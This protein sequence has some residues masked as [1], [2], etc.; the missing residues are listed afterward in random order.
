MLNLLLSI[1]LFAVL[2]FELLAAFVPQGGAAG[3]ILWLLLSLSLAV[4]A[5]YEIGFLLARFLRGRAVLTPLVLGVLFFLILSNIS[6]PY[7]LSHEFTQ[8]LGCALT[9]YNEQPGWGFRETCLFGYPA[10]QFFLPGVPSVLFGRSQETLNFGGSIWLLIGLSLFAAGLYRHFGRESSLRGDVLSAFALSLI[11]HFYYFNHFTFLYEQSIFPP[12]F[13]L[14]VVGLFA[15][16]FASNLYTYFLLGCTALLLAIYSYTPSMALVALG[17]AG[18]A[19]GFLTKNLPRKSAAL[20]LVLIGA[21]AAVSYTFRYDGTVSD[22]GTPASK[23]F[24]DLLA[25]FAQMLQ[26]TNG[27]YMASPWVHIPMLVVI[28]LA[29]IGALGFRMW[30]LSVWIVAVFSAAFVSR[31]YTYYEFSFRHHRALVAVPIILFLGSTLLRKFFVRP[32]KLGAVFAV[33]TAVLTGGA[34]Y[35]GWQFQDDYLR[36]KGA[37]RLLNYV[38]RINPKLAEEKTG[39]FFPMSLEHEY[40]SLNDFN[41]YFFPKGHSMLLPPD[42]NSD[43]TNQLDFSSVIILNNVK[44]EE[45]PE[46]AK[47]HLAGLSEGEELD[48]IQFEA[49]PLVTVRRYTKAVTQ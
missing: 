47:S 39:F 12:A 11:P 24:G 49:D 35:R 37:Q 43:F 16:Y 38:Q 46:C 34:L 30:G 41:A 32:G 15:S 29:L 21:S 25:G 18:L 36:S 6:K 19:F 10:R 26:F 40:I 13:A 2:P 42:C 4:A 33:L 14:M 31:G 48:Q 3:T 45:L 27:P 1:L 5:L 20:A 22:P 17:M 9:H 7:N 8:E 28:V 44:P 23:M